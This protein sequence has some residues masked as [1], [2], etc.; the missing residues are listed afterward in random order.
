MLN[1]FFVFV[2]MTPTFAQAETEAVR[3]RY[4]IQLS[5]PGY[6][7]F[8]YGNDFVYKRKAKI[9]INRNS[10]LVELESRH[11]L[12]GFPLTGQTT[13]GE[14]RIINFSDHKKM[15]AK[16]TASVELKFNLDACYSGNNS[17]SHPDFII[18][19]TIYDQNG[20][21]RLSSIRFFKV[22]LQTWNFYWV[23]A[24]GS[25]LDHGNIQ[26]RSDG[27][28]ASAKQTNAQ[29]KFN[30]DSVTHFCGGGFEVTDIKQ[31]GYPNG[32]L[33]NLEITHKGVVR[34]HYH[35]G[36]SKDLYQIALST[37]DGD[38]FLLML[39]PET[40]L[41]TEESGPAIWNLASEIG[42]ELFVHYYSR[43]EVIEIVTE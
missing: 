18:Y 23:D 7:S 16:S 1:L 24:D 37:F 9:A 32:R 39:N 28:L 12:L 20:N 27:T 3:P 19:P 4:S 15:T 5:G 42:T 11:R 21:S 25:Q 22:D 17:Q 36:Q 38:D 41:S 35:N 33:T 13:N 8:A 6:M 10:E 43:Q 29:L 40:F 2:S 31:D 34:A 14:P 26:F 30:A